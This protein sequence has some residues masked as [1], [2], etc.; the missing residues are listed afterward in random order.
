M[1]RE[2]ASWIGSAIGVLGLAA[3]SV[4]LGMNLLP[5]GEA[6]QKKLGTMAPVVITWGMIW[7]AV[8]AAVALA[9]FLIA[10]AV[11]KARRSQ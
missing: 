7:L 9:A 2:A 10:T 11:A 3:V 5:S 4:I 6:M 8:L 1:N